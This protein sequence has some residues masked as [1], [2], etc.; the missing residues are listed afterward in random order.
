MGPTIG[1]SA[2]AAKSYIAGLTNHGFAFALTNR[3]VSRAAV[4]ETKPPPWRILVQRSYQIEISRVLI[5]DR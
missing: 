3:F 2:A 5:A 1:S 4:P